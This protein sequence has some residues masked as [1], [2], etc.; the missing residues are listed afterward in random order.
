MYNPIG[1]YFCSYE[2]HCST[3]Y[4][5]DSVF[6][7]NEFKYIYLY[8]Y[9]FTLFRFPHIKRCIAFL[10]RQCYVFKFFWVKMDDNILDFADFKWGDGWWKGSLN[11]II[12]LHRAIWTLSSSVLWNVWI[13]RWSYLTL[14]ATMSSVASQSLSV[15]PPPAPD[16][17]H[18]SPAWLHQSTY[19]GEMGE[20]GIWSRMR[21]T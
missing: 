14:R 16:W 20:A 19:M 6:V 5:V 17:P 12:S 10:L 2:C 13:N 4:L 3:F 11:G 8:L 9:M 15:P 21:H 7:Y 1:G 18:N